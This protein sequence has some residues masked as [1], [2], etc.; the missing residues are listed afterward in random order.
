MEAYTSRGLYLCQLRRLPVSLVFRFGKVFSSYLR[1]ELTFRIRHMLRCAGDFVLSKVWF[2]FGRV[3][4]ICIV[5]WIQILPRNWFGFADWLHILR[6]AL[7]RLQNYFIDAD[8]L[9]LQ[10]S[11]FNIKL[12]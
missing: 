6:S 8:Q 9:L 10:I 2:S 12:I 5:Y 1:L 7:N 4:N 11:Q 3:D